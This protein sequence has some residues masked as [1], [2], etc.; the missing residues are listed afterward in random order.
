MGEPRRST[1]RS[2]GIRQKKTRTM[3]RGH[4]RARVL[5]ALSTQS[6]GRFE[7]GVARHDRSMG[8]TSGMV[9]MYHVRGGAQ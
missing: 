7:S 9:M 3:V 5:A 1:I 2:A 6:L 8:L 4:V